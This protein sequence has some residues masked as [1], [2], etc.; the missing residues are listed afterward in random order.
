MSETPDI[1]TA[2]LAGTVFFSTTGYISAGTIALWRGYPQ[3]FRYSF[4]T[5]L[6][7]GVT[8]GLFTG[9]IPSSLT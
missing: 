9:L 4:F 7:V 2:F 5:A 3:T 6:N 8:G 1:P